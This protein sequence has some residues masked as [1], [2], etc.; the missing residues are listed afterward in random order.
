MFLFYFQVN[1]IPGTQSCHF[2]FQYQ[3]NMKGVGNPLNQMDLILYTTVIL[4]TLFHSTKA[5]NYVTALNVS[6]ITTSSALLSWET[7][8]DTSN[9]GSYVIMKFNTDGE[10]V[11][12]ETT[13]TTISTSSYL[14]EELNYQTLYRFDILTLDNSDVPLGNAT[15][16]FVTLYKPLN[17]YALAAIA[18]AST[19]LLLYIVFFIAGKKCDPRQNTDQWKKEVLL[20]QMKEREEKR[21]EKQK[22]VSVQVVDHKTSA[23]R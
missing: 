3:D 7:P 12:N 13:I 15:V 9:I 6:D 4:G 23:D 10:N 20:L 11:R 2:S 1:P 16:S 8:D 5:A 18:I 22:K 21:K 14:L 17:R 19:I